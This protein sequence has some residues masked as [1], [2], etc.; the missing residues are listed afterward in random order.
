MEREREREGRREGGREADLQYPDSLVQDRLGVRVVVCDGQL[1]LA[2]VGLEEE[3]G[4]GVGAVQGLWPDRDGEFGGKGC[5]HVVFV[6]ADW[7]LSVLWG[8]L[9]R[10]GGRGGGEG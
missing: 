3:V 10:E 5:V 7:Q 4:L 1:C 9:E 6:M 8:I 2:E